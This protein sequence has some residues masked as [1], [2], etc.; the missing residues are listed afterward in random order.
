[1]W[2]L[3]FFALLLSAAAAHNFAVVGYLPE[4]RYEGFNYAYNARG[5]THLIFFSLE[6]GP[7]G[8]L[9]HTED[10]FPSN[11][12]LLEARTAF[13]ARGGHVLVCFGGNGRSAHFPSVTRSPT[14]RAAFVRNAVDFV[15]RKRLD[16]IDINWEYPG[17]RFGTG[18]LSSEE[19]AADYDGLLQLMRELRAALGPER[20]LTLAY[21][22]DGRQERLL[23]PVAPEVDLMHAMAYDQHGPE[24]SSFA[25]A[26]QTLAGAAAAGLPLAKVTLG[27]PFYG[28]SA[29]GWRSYEDLVQKPDASFN[30]NE[31]ALLQRKVRL[32][33]AR[34][35]AGVM[36]WEAG[37]DCRVEAVERNGRR[38]AVT[39][40]GGARDSLLVA[41][42]DALKET[43]KEL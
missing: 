38:H 25:L 3:S 37:Q 39:C 10:R 5:I 27:L 33:R 1:M 41:I 20:V 21:Y 23:R 42:M 13:R 17:F 36:I 15:A 8:S 19:I 18:Y 2:A 11:P 7:D 32:A 35:A 26:E 4:W 40:P 28:R 12:I 22:P 43:E 30:L 34:H 29:E 9:L 31:P 6:P 14:A 24:H 16:G